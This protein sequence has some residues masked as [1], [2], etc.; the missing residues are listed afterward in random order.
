MIPDIVRIIV[1]L[2]IVFFVDMAEPAEVIYTL[3]F[4]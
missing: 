4:E 1:P 2:I 3:Y